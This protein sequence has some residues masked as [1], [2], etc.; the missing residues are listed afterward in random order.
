MDP[1]TGECVVVEQPD[2]ANG[3]SGDNDGSIRGADTSLNGRNNTDFLFIEPKVDIKPELAFLLNEV[4]GAIA[5]A[6][7]GAHQLFL[8]RGDFDTFLF[9]ANSILW[10]QNQF[11]WIIARTI[12]TEWTRKW[13]LRSTK[14]VLLVPWIVMPVFYIWL[15][16]HHLY[17]INGEYNWYLVSLKYACFFSYGYGVR[18]WLKV[19]QPSLYNYWM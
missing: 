6:A 3:D 12:D 4:V 10:G 16:F 11:M 19:I 14:G 5:V 17:D 18:E 9:V 15:L 1:F 7:V 8:K 2:D 13:Y